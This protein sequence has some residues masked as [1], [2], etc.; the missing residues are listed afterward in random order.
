MPKDQQSESSESTYL[1]RLRFDPK[2][3]ASRVASY[4]SSLRLILLVTILVVVIGI[5]SYLNLP[6]NLY[7]EIK[8]PIVIVSTVLPGA[9]PSDVES[10]VTIPLED[11]VR[12]VSGVK[13]VSSTSQDSVSVIS[14]EFNSGIDPEKA[15]S[16]IKSAIDSVSELP[17]D[18]QSP[19]VTKIDFQNQPVWTFEIVSSKSPNDLFRLSQNLK[20]DLENLTTVD[21]V[22]VSGNEEQEI[23]ILLKPSVVA[24]Y[25]INPQ[26]L[27]PLIKTSLKSLPAGS[28]ETSQ[29][30][31]LLTIDP[32]VITLDDLR[33]L[34][35][36]LNGN[37]VALG[38]IFEISEKSKLDQPKAFL[39]SSTGE[40]KRAVN[41]QVF[42]TSG[43]NIESVVAES[44]KE[45]D[46][47]LSTYGSTFKVYSVSDSGEEISTQFSHLQQDFLLTVFL[48]T[49]ILFIFLG[50]KQA[51]VASFTTPLVFF[52]TFIVMTIF[53]ITLNFIS[54]F[55]LL[56]SLGL[57]VDDTIV[58]ISALTSY[59]RSG[60][61]TPFQAGLLVWRDFLIPV[62]TTTITTVWAFLPLLISTGII[63]EFIKPIPVVVST[64]LIASILVALL[65]TFPLIIFLLKA[66]VPA[67]VKTMLKVVVIT[68]P[69]I[70]LLIL[71]PKDNNVFL[72]PLLFLSLF[73]FITYQIRQSLLS[74]F[75]Q[76]F[77][78]GD[79]HLQF[80][81]FV[82]DKISNGLISFQPLSHNYK[83]LILKILSSPVARRQTIIM[84]IIFS[85][86]SIA[87]FPLGLLKNEFFPKT[88]QNI[89]YVSAQLPPGT[90]IDKVNSQMETLLSKFPK[91]EEINFIS[92]VAG[93]S[94]S[95]FGSSQ[96]GVNNIL[97]TIELK[98]KE[99]RSKSSSEIADLLRT[100]F[101]N[102]NSAQITV[103]EQSGGPPAGADLQIKLF[104][105]DLA[106]L[107]S[108]ANKIQSHLKNEP[109]VINT[110][111]SIK[112]GISKL[113]FTPDK[114]KLTSLGMS[115]DQIGFWL[116]LYATGITAD[117]IKLDD[118]SSDKH[119][120]NIRLSKNSPQA[121]DLS[122]LLIPTSQGNLPI[123]S[124]GEITLEQNPTLITREGGKRTI[125]ITAG[126]KPGYS[127]T[128]LNSDLEKYA[129]E[130]NLPSNYS[131]QTGGVNEQNQESVQT[132]LVAMVLS[133]ILIVATMVVQFNSFRRALIVI[134][135]IPLSIS[136]V[137]VM[138]GLTQTALTFPALIGVLAL[139]G[140]VVKNSILIVDKIVANLKMG[141]PFNEAI[142]DGASSRLEAIAL[143]S[144]CAIFGLIPITLSDPLWRGLGGAIIAGLTFSGTIMLFFIPVTY[145]FFYRGESQN[146]D[147]V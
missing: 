142:A 30:S 106:M 14:A 141:L 20:K 29:S 125:S 40:Q 5:V 77:L 62:L 7:P 110:D 140:I 54:V 28:V 4:L 130:L 82:S 70:F 98:D 136:G 90:N 144:F 63:G 2:L 73:V 137:F 107:D 88:D 9:G 31:L 80:K 50:A 91:L 27:I 59:F 139:F 74:N 21:H 19:N 22:N 92:A 122:T 78:Q 72:I 117:K 128:T 51:L 112:P 32:S 104:G 132:I 57:L 131:W 113:V 108:M 35:T 38:D 121:A 138:F 115:V 85:L 69:F 83:N 39:R 147:K 24:S 76:K 64:A 34:R 93:Q 129:D 135:V 11:A 120:I 105:P 36:N 96:G 114:Q 66:E 143:T 103:S 95:D 65:I 126:V 10:L 97:F 42:R 100:K 79:R 46:R 87:L 145:Y 134:L 127:V 102:D 37:I 25:S 89:L 86:F 67:R 84:V 146:K 109:G 118:D 26:Q 71:V 8:I 123:T 47:Q 33:S 3:A 124:L 16:D 133:I 23:Q 6:R 49:A 56:L 60:K 101:S 48:V 99:H 58:V 55:S 68:T 1:S 111:K 18:A 52:I 13:T 94:L 53:G 43:A 12:G 41:F 17:S 15:R 44:K 81:D 45:V 119:E 116:R 75:K 61:F